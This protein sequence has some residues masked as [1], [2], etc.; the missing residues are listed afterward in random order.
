MSLKNPD[1]VK[2]LEEENW[3]IDFPKKKKSLGNRMKAIIILMLIFIFSILFLLFFYGSMF[4]IKITIPPIWSGENHQESDPSIK[5]HMEKSTFHL[6]AKLFRNSDGNHV[7]SPFITSL[8][9]S[10]LLE[11]SKKQTAS[12]IASAMN[13]NSIGVSEI[14]SYFN[15]ALSYLNENVEKIKIANGM[16]VENSI[17]VTDFYKNILSK[18][19]ADLIK[20]GFQSKN[21]A[22][23]KI[24]T[25]GMEKSEGLIKELI[26][27][28]SLNS[29]ALGIISSLMT[30]RGKWKIPFNKNLTEKADFILEDGT[31]KKVKMMYT[32]NYFKSGDFPEYNYSALELSYDIPDIVMLI[33]LPSNMQQFKELLFKTN[34]EFL[35][36]HQSN[37]KN[38]NVEVCLPKFEIRSNMLLEEEIQSLGIKDLFDS[39]T[40]NMKGIAFNEDFYVKKIFQSAQIAVD[41]EATEG[42][43]SS[44]AII[45]SRSLMSPFCVDRPFLF[46]VQDKRHKTV[47]FWGEYKTPLQ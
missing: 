23:N 21:E 36:D 26:P 16:F 5:E 44:S 17:D 35:T 41:E 12:N 8:I 47:L 42:T 18:Y 38:L 28:D 2:C 3:D 19:N 7:W 45:G 29:D 24:N 20:V 31:S 25:W 9:M 46:Y 37:M 39:E 27:S 13:W 30:F 43:A 1:L 14:R 34:G 32:S 6:I 40:S 11:G 22:L 10:L 33:L 15:N 4:Q